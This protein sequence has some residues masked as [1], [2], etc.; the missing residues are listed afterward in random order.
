MSV[1]RL[2]LVN[3]DVQ[4][5]GDIG[6]FV[7][8]LEIQPDFEVEGFFCSDGRKH[9]FRKIAY[10]SRIR[11][12]NT[13]GNMIARN[14]EKPSVVL[15][16]GK[17]PLSKIGEMGCGAV[18]AVANDHGNLKD[19]FPYISINVKRDV[20]ENIRYQNNLANNPIG[21]F[22]FNQKEGTKEP[23]FWSKINDNVLNKKIYEMLQEVNFTHKELER[24]TGVQ[25]P[26]VLL[27]TDLMQTDYTLDTFVANSDYRLQGNGQD[28]FQAGLESMR[29]GVL[30]SLT[31]KPSFANAKTLVV[32]FEN[33]QNHPYLLEIETQL[34]S[35]E[36]KDYQKRGGQVIV[37][38]KP[39]ESSKLFAYELERIA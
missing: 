29:Y 1:D 10:E 20:I 19:N 18:D 31:D 36:I 17:S 28:M 37:V 23:V 22:Y 39:R 8:G 21:G 4:R 34:K 24:M 15:G 6:S 26:R 13:A 35:Q 30:H 7:F 33:L 5:A 11:T 16:H 27:W 14:R 3:Y 32:A 2:S 25:D 38:D 12:I 9:K